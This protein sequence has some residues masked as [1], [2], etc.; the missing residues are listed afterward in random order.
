VAYFFWE[1]QKAHAMKMMNLF[2]FL[3]CG[4]LLIACNNQNDQ[5]K[6]V[7]K[8]PSQVQPPSQAITNS[9]KLVNDSVIVPDT[10]PNNRK[11]VGKSD[12]LQKSKH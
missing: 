11:Q 10:T 1:K 3:L 6:G 2:S 7:E 5:G 12:S 4:S 9:T 8:D